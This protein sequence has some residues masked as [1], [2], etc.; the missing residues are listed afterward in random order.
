MALKEKIQE[1]QYIRKVR[2]D[3]DVLKDIPNQS[4]NIIFEAFHY[5]GLKIIP[6]I[7][8][9]TPELYVELEEYCSQALICS[10]SILSV[11]PESKITQEICI[12]AINWSPSLF[13]DL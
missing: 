2:K 1:W 8:D 6:F 4:E 7:R 11:L 3:V 10:E 9:L 12:G 13:D 5:H